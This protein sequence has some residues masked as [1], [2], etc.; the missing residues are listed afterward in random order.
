MKK[1]KEP[2]IRQVRKP[3]TI[4]GVEAVYLCVL[5]IATAFLGWLAENIV[6]IIS[7]GTFDCR[8][9]LLP[10]IS[11]YALIVFA[12]HIVF[13]NPDN[14]APFGRQ[15]FR[16][17]NPYSKICSNIL[18][19]AIIY[20]FV[21][22]GELIVGNTWEIL[23]GVKL[24]NYSSSPLHVTQYAGLIPTL[25][26]GTGAYLLFRFVH[27]PSLKFLQKNMT[28]KTALILSC[29]LGVLI[30]LDTLIMILVTAI[31]RQA[32]MYWSVHF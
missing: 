11:P 28:H 19:L 16:N 6:K 10:F 22:F 15:L 27:T 7:N 5:G 25:G 31:T 18:V 12:V 2:K 9:H 17:D 3:F 1:T 29:T 14:I 30:V 21:F 4:F 8:F 32:P 23:F 13:G 26:Y 24:W 20:I